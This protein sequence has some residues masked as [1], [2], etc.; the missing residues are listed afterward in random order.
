MGRIILDPSVF[1]PSYNIG[2]T[3]SLRSQERG[4][5]TPEGIN[6]AIN[7]ASLVGGLRLPKGLSDPAVDAQGQAMQFAAQRRAEAKSAM[8]AREG[9]VR[10]RTEQMT[11]GD[12]GKP[13]DL[14]TL[15]EEDRDQLYLNAEIERQ[16]RNLN[17]T[18]EEMQ[19]EGEKGRKVSGIEVFDPRKAQRKAFERL[20]KQD[21]TREEFERARPDYMDRVGTVQQNLREAQERRKLDSGVPAK[22]QQVR[23]G[24]GPSAE[25]MTPGAAP[26]LER[27]MRDPMRTQP[28]EVVDPYIR[29]GES[30]VARLLDAGESAFS[31]S[32]NPQIEAIQQNLLQTGYDVGPNGADGQFGVD[33]LKALRAKAQ[34]IRTQQ[35][36]PMP[37]DQ[38]DG[39]TRLALQDL[40]D[41]GSAA[42]QA[43]TRADV[44]EEL[45][46][47]RKNRPSIVMG[48]AR[49]GGDVRDADM[50]EELL[51]RQ[52]R[53]KS[54]VQAAY[55]EGT[56]AGF[57]DYGVLAP[58]EV[59]RMTE[60][61]LEAI[62]EIEADKFLAGKRAD[63]PYFGM[64]NQDALMAMLRDAPNATTAEQQRKLLSLVPRYTG[65]Y[66]KFSDFFFDDRADRVV[67]NAARIRQFFPEIQTG[68]TELDKA[69]TG[70]IKAEEKNLLAKAEEAK[71][72][73]LKTLQGLIKGKTQSKKSLDQMFQRLRTDTREVFSKRMGISAQKFGLKLTGGSLSENIANL[74]GKGQL[75]LAE[76]NLLRDLQSVEQLELQAMKLIRQGQEAQLRG[77]TK[78]AEAL[79][80]Q[81]MKDLYGKVPSP[82][83]EK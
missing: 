64:S 15:S 66:T 79:F 3:R 74:Q 20:S 47:F 37:L 16:F 27:A 7:L 30:L 9:R 53:R 83:E 61:E 72:R 44:L 24:T 6:T 19:F 14:G 2:P 25:R 40:K 42:V 52:L 8:E 63:D 58:R 81:L 21:L 17:L 23:M 10:A 38:I 46:E 41:E 32:Y 48:L 54:K 26:G 67:K 71:A 57:E 77:N 43:M 73:S 39:F 11:A 78:R 12:Y 56:I 82:P 18:D 70:K 55:E 36:G 4:F 31:Y 34:G 22:E 60:D 33:T 45:S 69:K 1:Q 80:R 65:E 50:Y 59:K 5:L 49:S 75:S 51:M 13:G 76:Q 62:T 28:M 68:P 35:M 29:A